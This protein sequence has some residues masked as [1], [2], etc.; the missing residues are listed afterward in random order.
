MKTA[1]LATAEVQIDNL[2]KEILSK[3]NT[4]KEALDRVTS[5]QIKLSSTEAR[6]EERVKELTEQIDDLNRQIESLKVQHDNTIVALK[7]QSELH[8]EGVQREHAKKSS[9]ARMLVS[10]KEEEVRLLQDKV[11]E[12]QAEIAS[13]APAERKIFELANLQARRDA[14][15]GQHA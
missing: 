8:L 2:K 15:H 5:L 4:T 10:E 1:M 9:T 6:L 14:A 3:E 13:G 12:L 11:K 7:E